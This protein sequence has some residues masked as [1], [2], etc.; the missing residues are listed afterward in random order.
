MSFSICYNENMNVYIPVIFDNDKIIASIHKVD[1]N[2]W[3]L[4]S[5]KMTIPLGERRNPVSFLRDV[6]QIYIGERSILH[7]ELCEDL[8]HYP[9]RECDMKIEMAYHEGLYNVRYCGDNFFG[10]TEDQVL[11][12]MFSRGK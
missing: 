1:K 11:N 4:R 5:N 7:L 8:P 6:E 2:S 3:V 10:I 12:M 9:T